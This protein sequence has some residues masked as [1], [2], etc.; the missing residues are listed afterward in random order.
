MLTSAEIP[1]PGGPLSVIADDETV[2]AARFAALQEVCS[3]A[4]AEG[5]IGEPPEGEL[6][7][8]ITAAIAAFVDGDTSALN[9]VPVRQPGTEFSQGVWEAMRHIPPGEVMTYGDLA[10]LVGRPAAARAVGQACARN[11]V[12]PFVPCHRVV[13]ASGGIGSYGYGP[14]VK[15]ALLRH[16]GWSG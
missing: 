16:E 12:A 1:T 13:P 8:S 3:Q 5:W 4:L 6:P 11:R 7:T 14:E 10:A 2:V 9:S 15:E